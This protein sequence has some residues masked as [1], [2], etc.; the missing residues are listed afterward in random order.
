[1]IILGIDPGSMSGAIAALH[2]NRA[3][4]EVADLPVVG[5]KAKAR[6]DVHAL[7]DWIRSHKPGHCFI[8]RAQAFPG[9]GAS[10]G[11]KY[12]RATGAVEATVM[13][14]GVP[15]TIV[16][17]SSWKKHYRLKG[18]DKESARALAIQLHPHLA[19]SLARVKDHGRAEALLIARF[20]LV[21]L[22]EP[23]A[24]AA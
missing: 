5:V 13:M 1:M 24:L 12:G 9:Q 15:L 3:A 6:I 11:F 18:A 20:G 10:S 4:D 22:G 8:E 7:A 17:A 16:E 19:S 2:D 14:C 23:T 21:L